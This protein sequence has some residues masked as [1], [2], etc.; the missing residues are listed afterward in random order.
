MPRSRRDSRPWLGDHGYGRHAERI[1]QEQLRVPLIWNGPRVPKGMQVESFVRTVDI[2]PTLCDLK[3]LPVP[4]G[5]DGASLAALFKGGE[6]PD[7]TCYAETR[8]P[9]IDRGEALF[10][11]IK[12]RRKLIFA[13]DSGR[14]EYYDLVAD[15]TEQRNL[16]AQGGYDDLL[17]ELKTHDLSTAAAREEN[18]DPEVEAGLAALGYVE[19]K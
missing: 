8:H 11:I 19:N 1:Y 13:P 15:P 2:L 3:G 16:A 7:R 9:L 18:V 6:Q 4:P 17:A 14:Y 10:S 12:N 5:L